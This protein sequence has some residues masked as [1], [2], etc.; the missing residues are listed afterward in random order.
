MRLISLQSGSNG[1]CVYVESGEVRLLFDAGISGKQAELR[2]A[3]HG[4]DIRQVQAVLIS[5]DHSDH[6]RSLGVFHRKFGLPVHVTPRTLLQAGTGASLGTLDRIEHFAAGSS[7]QFGH[8]TVETIRT[9]H[10]GVDGVAFVVDDGRRRL[11]ILTDLGHIFRGLP[12]LLGSLDAVLLESNYDP[13]MLASGWY[14]AH[15]KRRIRGPGGH[16]SNEEAATLVSV[17]TNGRLRWLCLGHL[18]QENNTPERA[19]ATHR[20]ILGDRLSI[21]LA[22]RYEASAV[23]EV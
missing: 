2:L 10:D 9:P 6:S 5:H 19:L 7:L 12:E 15:L 8:V 11:G 18:S 23:L 3:R 16:L 14:P 13:R 22:S 4:R 20:E 17:S 21:H 1:N